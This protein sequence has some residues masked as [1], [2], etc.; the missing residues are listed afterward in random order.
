MIFHYSHFD[1]R[2]IFIIFFYFYL[3]LWL[4]LWWVNCGFWAEM[5][6][7]LGFPIHVAYIPIFYL[8]IYDTMQIWTSLFKTEYFILW[9]LLP[10][11]QLIASYSP[12]P[13]L[14]LTRESLVKSPGNCTN[15]TCSHSTN[16]TI[17][18]HF[19]LLEET[20]NISMTTQESNLLTWQVEFL[21]SML[22]TAIL[23]SMKYLQI[24]L[25]N[26]CTF[27]PS[28]YTNIMDNT[29]K[30]CVLNWEKDFKLLISATLEVKLMISLIC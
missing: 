18:S 4:C 22:V 21:L 8:F 29:L 14:L 26:L 5:D 28:I 6:W 27:P 7:Y 11:E 13:S 12:T 24:R 30:I 9:G 19:M 16:H 15:S 1:I 10:K 25:K 23:G 2:I 17:K 20:G 3:L